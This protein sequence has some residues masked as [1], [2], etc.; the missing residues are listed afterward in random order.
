VIFAVAT[1]T[2]SV[3][4]EL[5]G[6]VDPERARHLAERLAGTARPERD[7]VADAAARTGA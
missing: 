1:A 5:A 2:A 7:L 4:Q 3:E 6:G